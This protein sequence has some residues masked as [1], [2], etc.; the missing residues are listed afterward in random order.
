[1]KERKKEVLAIDINVG[2][3]GME[4]GDIK[5][6]LQHFRSIFNPFDNTV[7]SVRFIVYR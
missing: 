4:H 2:V 7:R 6:E 5:A 1:M 3:M